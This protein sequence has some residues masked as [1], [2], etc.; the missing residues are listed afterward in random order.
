MKQAHQSLRL[1]LALAAC[2]ATTP[3]F[4]QAGPSPDPLNPQAAVP[5]LQYRSALQRLQPR[6]APEAGAWQEHNARVGRIGGWRAYAR[7]AQQ[8]EGAA[9]APAGAHRHHHH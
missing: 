6:S 3:A 4:A 9:S 7:E 5:P 1:G 8:P 2:L